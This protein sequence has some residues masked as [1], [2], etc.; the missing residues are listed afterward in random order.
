MEKLSINI[1]KTRNKMHNLINKEAEYSSILKVS[2][3]LD[4]LIALFMKLKGAEMEELKVSSKTDV[5]SL[6]GAIAG[7]VKDNGKVTIKGIGAGAINQI[8]KAIAVARGYLASGGIDLICIPAF[9]NISIE[10]NET[11]TGIKVIA[12][13]R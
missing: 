3:E 10:K 9:E 1:V 5:N 7:N 13:P 12:E 4:K 11:R 8:M 2:Q 6:A